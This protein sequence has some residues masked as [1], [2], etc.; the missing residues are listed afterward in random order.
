[1]IL[2]LVDKILLH[3]N[4]AK[5]K[6]IKVG[7]T[8]TDKECFIT[9]IV[10][11]VESNHKGYFSKVNEKLDIILSNEWYT[12]FFYEMGGDEE[13]AGYKAY[14]TEESYNRTLKRLDHPDATDGKNFAKLLISEY[15][16][17][18]GVLD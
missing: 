14:S 16:A 7:K 9:C 3:V 5:S 15:I 8:N 13:L 17:R 18:G 1:M 4:N 10:P 6:G 12:G 2:S 11:N